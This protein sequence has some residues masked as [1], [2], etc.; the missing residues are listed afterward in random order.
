MG[1]FKGPE[2]VKKGIALP[3]PP[4][5]GGVGGIDNQFLINGFSIKPA[6]IKKGVKII[7][8]TDN[9]KK[10]WLKPRERWLPLLLLTILG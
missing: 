4:D 2:D 10:N 8:P 6:N 9:H 3:Y 7:T 5:I 1:L